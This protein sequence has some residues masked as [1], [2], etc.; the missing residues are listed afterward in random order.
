MSNVLITIKIKI[1]LIEYCLMK[2]TVAKGDY[3]YIMIPVRS[4]E[5]SFSRSSPLPPSKCTDYV[6]FGLLLKNFFSVI[7]VTH[8][9]L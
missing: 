4:L 5:L 3:F 8:I 7:K 1:L 6:F 9:S 2:Y